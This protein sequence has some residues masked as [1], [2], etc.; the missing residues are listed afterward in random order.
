MSTPD[1]TL[2]RRVGLV[3]GTSQQQRRV[4]G[5]CCRARDLY[6]ASSFQLARQWCEVACDEWAIISTRH[7]L[8]LPSDVVTPYRKPCPRTHGE[9]SLWLESVNRAT[10]DRWQ[11]FRPTVFILFTP[12]HYAD[13]FARDMPHPNMPHQT[14]LRALSIVQR[15][16]WLRDE[17]THRVFEVS[18]AL[19]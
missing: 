15:V 3:A 12:D 8:L 7:G 6:L 5:R 11:R 13:A 1:P 16:Q 10:Y 2:L 14:P 18:H 4:Q 9:R 17:L 19:E